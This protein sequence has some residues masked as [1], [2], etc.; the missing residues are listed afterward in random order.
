VTPYGKSACRVALLAALCAAGCGPGGA[1]PKTYPVKGRVTYADGRPLA[2]G[3]I[4]FRSAD[5]PSLR[6]RGDIGP[7]GAFTLRTFLDDRSVPG[8]PAGTYT[9]TYMSHLASDAPEQ[10]IP[11]PPVVLPTPYT[12]EPRD[13]NDLAVTL[14][15]SS[16]PP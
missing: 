4:E 16:G 2:G 1:V 13:G 10:A 11:P 6:V 15:P 8:A 14:P 7:D 12:V 3:L 9:A 5:D